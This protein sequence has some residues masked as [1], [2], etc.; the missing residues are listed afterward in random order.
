[1]IVRRH[2]GKVAL[3][4]WFDG[5]GSG[6]TGAHVARCGRC[7]R[8]VSELAR[9]RSWLRAQPFVA[10]G[11]D[12]EDRVDVHANAGRRTGRRPL[13]LVAALVM[14]FALVAERS[15][16][17]SDAPVAFAPPSTAAGART[18]PPTDALP[19]VP[20][21]GDPEVAAV[22]P[23]SPPQLS[24]A[25][26]ARARAAAPR[27][28]EP[29]R[30]GLVVPR[31]GAMAAEGDEVV[32]VVRQR[33][34]AANQAGGVAGVPVE[35]EVAPAEDAAAVA[36]MAARVRALVGGFGVATAPDALW[37]LPAD[38]SIVGPKVVP[39][40]MAARQAGAHLA[41]VLRQQ[42]LQGP[43]GVVVGSGPDAALA[44]GLATRVSTTTVKAGEDGTCLA[45][46]TTLARSG[47][48]A[49]AVAGSP[50]LAASCLRAASRVAWDR[51]FGSVLAP[52]AAY[53]GLQDLPEALG[54]RT[55]L[56]LPWPTS[57]APGAA[58]FRATALS[59]SYRALVSYA[60][61][62]LA[63]DVAR[64][65]DDLSLDSVAAGDWRSDLFDL[66]GTSSRATT[67]VVA[68][69]GSWLIAG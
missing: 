57:T 53:A 51:S 52:S 16:P 41:G 35:L 27:A 29:L 48:A 59:T 11:D 1:M 26:Q 6:R 38:T 12:D 46:V 69:L 65:H 13:G 10:M 32:K 60:A 66:S 67:L 7:Q 47:A 2:P 24:V 50:D 39:A 17:H 31:S 14:A 3:G 64:R 56:N 21:T 49:L 9:L 20:A 63:I 25:E 40:E 18:A 61:T 8:H 54:A 5:E 36:A 55:V 22:A 42:G 37:L 43:V 19:E 15:Q 28:T 30:L 4:A 44:A 34:D 23:S 45:E 62:E 33:V 68:F 58:R